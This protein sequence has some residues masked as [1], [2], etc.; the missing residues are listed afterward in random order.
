MKNI[1]EKTINKFGLKK[2]DF[3]WI[4]LK[5]LTSVGALVAAGFVGAKLS[6]VIMESH[7]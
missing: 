1:K 4:V 7:N 6:D 5:G 3:N 2:G